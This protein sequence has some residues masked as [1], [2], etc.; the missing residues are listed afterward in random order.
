MSRLP[1]LTLGVAL[2]AATIPGPV[3]AQ[4][5]AVQSPAAKPGADNRATPAA[6]EAPAADEII[7][8]L[9]G[10]GRRPVDDTVPG[11][12]APSLSPAPSSDPVPTYVAPPPMPSS[13]TIQAGVVQPGMAQ[14]GMAQPGTAFGTGRPGVTPTYVAPPPM[15]TTAPAN[16]PSIS[17]TVQFASGSWAISPAAER[18]LVP[19]GQAL[20]SSLLAGFRFRI[21]G[22]TD[23]VGADTMNL[24][25]SQRRAEAVRAYLVSRFGVPAERL[26]A[27][28]LGESQLLVPT[29]DNMPEARNRRVQVLNLGS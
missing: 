19:L 26:D 7:R 13:G 11:G 29:L 20:S 5:P 21:E 27:I 28:G 6:G 2:A 9:R 15:A 8:R 22:H 24:D 16:V 3:A 10:I 14:P 4:S 18:A 25:L 1:L 12:A 23:T 17:L